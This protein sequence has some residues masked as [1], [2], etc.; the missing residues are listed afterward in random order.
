MINNILYLMF[1]DI[2]TYAIDHLGHDQENHMYI[3]DR[4]FE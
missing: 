4:H 1:F 2:V 3:Q